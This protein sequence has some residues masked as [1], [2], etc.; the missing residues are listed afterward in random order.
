MSICGKT[1]VVVGEVCCSEDMTIDARIDGP[2]LCEGRSVTLASSAVVT[3]DVVAADITVFG[4]A[5]GQLIA[6]D[7]VDLRAG[8]VASGA[9]IA[10][11]LIL[12][13]GAR[14]SGRVDPLRLEAALSV[15]RFQQKQRD[16][17][18]G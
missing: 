14:F 11:S 16:T 4:R 13:D 17:K 12:H 5:S 6:T 1:V 9:V 18:T 7:V 15:V 10:P 2:V 3:G 8:A